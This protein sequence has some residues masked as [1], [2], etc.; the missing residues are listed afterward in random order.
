MKAK[1]RQPTS[2]LTTLSELQIISATLTN[3]INSDKG[4]RATAPGHEAARLVIGINGVGTID[5]KK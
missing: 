4:Q 1:A 5:L 3:R 2:A